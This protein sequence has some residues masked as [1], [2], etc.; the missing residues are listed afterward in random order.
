MST[1]IPR[2]GSCRSAAARVLGVAW[3]VASGCASSAVRTP[4]PREPHPHAVGAFTVRWRTVVHGHG[5]FEPA[6]GECASGVVVRDLVIVGSRQ[7][8]VFGL[9]RYSGQVRWTTAVSGGVDSRASYDPVL[10]QVYVGADDGSLSALGARDGRL[11]WT[12]RA[13]GAIEQPPSSNDKAVFLATAADKLYALQPKTGALL[14]QY[15]RDTPE[16]FTIHGHAG[17]SA[18]GERVFSGFTDGFLVSLGAASGEVL[19]TKSLAS[20]SDQFVDVDSTPLVAG[21]Q[22]FAASY[23]GGAYALS[24]RDGSVR[25]HIAVEGAGPATLAPG[26]SVLYFAAPRDGLHAVAT[27]SGEIL[28]RQGLADAGDVTAPQ[29]VGELLLF[30]GSRAGVF[31]VDRRDGRILQTFN[32]GDGVCGAPALDPGGTYA[33]VLANSGS[34]Y[35][36]AVEQP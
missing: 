18:A 9:D 32:P 24:A 31:A 28:W 3:L 34:L 35:A 8:R 7:G 2:R 36:L 20:T 17:P 6:P 19:W 21:D 25:W 11:R 1:L 26:G 10:D 30:S 16:G 13:R 14:W 12:Y 33:Y 29:V 5:L 22:L 15:E 27:S 23:T 4:A